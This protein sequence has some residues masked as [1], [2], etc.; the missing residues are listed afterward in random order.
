MQLFILL[1]YKDLP[2]KTNLLCKFSSVFFIIFWY[3]Q[4][5]CLATYMNLSIDFGVV[6]YNLL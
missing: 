2:F 5:L 6:N 1:I 4:N 3:V